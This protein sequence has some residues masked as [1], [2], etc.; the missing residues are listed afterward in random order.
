MIS[1][2]FLPPD[3]SGFGSPSIPAEFSVVFAL[4]AI[5]VVAGIG[6]SIYVGV[7]KYAILKQAGHDPLTVDAALAAKVLNSDLLRPGTAVDDAAP[8]KS[9]EERLSEVDSLHARGVISD[10]ERAAA[11][12][13]ILRG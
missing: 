6:F 8:A 7:R 4:F 9:L 12:A 1:A 10:D 5:V 3:D 11:R 13:S 2:D